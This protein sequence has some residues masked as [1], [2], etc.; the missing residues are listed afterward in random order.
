MQRL[1]R[2]AISCCVEG[3][4]GL[5]FERECARLTLAG[6]QL[7]ESCHSRHFFREASFV[8]SMVLSHI[9]AFEIDQTISSIGTPSDFTVVLDPISLGHG[10]FARHGTVLTMAA[11]CVSSVNH[12][13]HTLM[14]AAPT[15]G[16]GGHSGAS[17]M[18]LALET[19]ERH[20][21]HF[22]KSCLQARLSLVGGDGGL[23]QGVD[24]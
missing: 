10:W 17:I 1:V 14:I 2:L 3:R 7:G 21:G 13:V 24:V 19:L 9:D 4:S 6:V 22:S 23:T 20:P 8:S 12:K 15:M 5:E 16:L 11:V 18:N